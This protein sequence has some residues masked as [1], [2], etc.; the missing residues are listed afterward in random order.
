MFLTELLKPKVFVELGVHSGNSY[1]AF[2][3]A[4]DML[5]LQTKAFGVDSWK[6]DEQAGHYGS[7]VYT[8]LKEYHDP[9]YGRISSL[10]RSTFDQASNKF[11]QKSID[12]LH[13]DGY[14]TYEAVTHDFCT[15]LPK[16]SE[17]GVILFH[18]IC[19][20]EDDFGV[21]QLWDELK[22]DYPYFEFLHGNGL[23]ILATG[24]KSPKKLSILL[25][26]SEQA[27][28]IREFF[29]IRGNEIKQT[30]LLKEQLNQLTISIQE[31][32]S[33]RTYKF[34]RSLSTIYQSLHKPFSRKKP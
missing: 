22:K 10:V 32:E 9:L 27:D 7:K 18:D 13:I 6:G 26:N 17:T 30:F 8:D 3:Q 15:W 11:E 19:V 2:C 23:G 29:S 33:S 20:K 34:S 21:W 14:H 24:S 16:M 12:L 1:C 4:I 31:I 28:E 5:K 25:E